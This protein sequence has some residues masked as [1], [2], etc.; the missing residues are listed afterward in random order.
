[1]IKKTLIYPLALAILTVV[2]IFCYL[3]VN[4]IDT[5]LAVIIDG[6]ELSHTDTVT[7]GNNS[8][9]CFNQIPHD[10]LLITKA[11]DAFV[12][13][14]NDQYQDSLQYF[15]INNE[16]P[17]KHLIH[18]DSR[19]HISLTLP[20]CVSDSQDTIHVNLTG[21]EIWKLWE[22]F[23][24]QQDVMVHWL[25]MKFL[26][27]KEDCSHEDSLVFINQMQNNAV[28]SFFEKKNSDQIVMVILD[29]YTSINETIKY[30]YNG[31]TSAVADTAGHCKVQFFG[32]SSYCYRNEEPEKNT[33]HV[34]G[35]NYV[36]KPY[37]KLTEWG[38]GHIML[39]SKDK[40]LRISFPKPVTF[41]GSID[42]LRHVA[43]QTS[44][45]ISLKQS[46][47]AFPT[48]GDMYLPE[49][50]NAINYDLCNI[51]FVQS[52]DSVYIRD[53]NY[54]VQS[55]AHKALLFP[56]FA[57][58]SLSSGDDELTGRVGFINQR[59]V[60]NYLSLPLLLFFIFLI[61]I[62]IKGSPFRLSSSNL[63]QL[64]N[65][66]HIQYYPIYLTTLLTVCLAYCCC[67]SL[68]AIKLSYT[69]P[70]FEKITGII[71]AST[72]MTM[73]LFFSLTMIVNTPL[74]HIT[75]PSWKS[76]RLW[77]GWAVCTVL[78]GLLAYFFFNEIDPQI[79]EGV[80]SS[81]FSSE[82]S[83]ISTIKEGFN[84]DAILDTHRSVVYI[85]IAV[86]AAVLFVWMILNF[87]WKHIVTTFDWLRSKLGKLWII[88]HILL[89][90]FII[91]VGNM[92]GNFG[93]AIITLLVILG[94]SHAL[95]QMASRMT[96]SKHQ[97]R[98][99]WLICMFFTT[100]VYMIAAFWGDHGYLTNYLGFIMFFV[101]ISYMSIRPDTS[102]DEAAY[103]ATKKEKKWVYGLLGVLTVLAIT[104]PYLYI[105]TVGTESVDYSRLN[106]RM[107]LYMEFDDLQKNG[108][109]YSD[110][111]AEFMVIMSHYMQGQETCDPLSNDFHT[112]HASVSSGQS[113]V[114]LND[115]SVPIAFFG[116]YGTV[117]PIAVFFLLLLTLVLLVTK[118]SIDYADHY[119]PAFTVAMQWRMLAMMMWV[120]TS[121]YIFLSYISWLPFTGRL[122]PGF[123]VD[124]VG[125]ALET[126]I[127][128]TFMAATTCRKND[129]YQ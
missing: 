104:L 47:D 4:K 31:K 33:F 10:Y 107:M 111:D 65:K 117:L 40:G 8:S 14:V 22:K 121:C 54:H 78:L 38:A 122:N 9:I 94:L 86:E 72:S 1:M 80:L 126:A 58:I 91:V 62:W 89:L 123:G 114:V 127:L 105:W 92:A 18:N 109:R 42:S 34:D 44:G 26:L 24:K 84:T 73:L 124:A 115:L 81:Y 45:L 76:P 19:Q 75:N 69:Y 21:A 125:E 64:Y 43:K 12:W 30:A 37:V 87:L 101:C 53:N 103:E 85:L 108:Y 7:V 32:I 110:S 112:M 61:F 29:R 55:V 36:M 51:E 48:K 68:I 17:N 95:S 6:L 41:V 71:T 82:T 128:L 77:S 113:P 27:E 2:F 67:K 98:G 49:F 39:E 93:T 99:G 57:K 23:D 70:Y 11:G 3:M 129:Y 96:T 28:R 20:P 102:Y 100:I 66:E 50:S 16:N 79:N 52:N 120:G 119:S 13:E 15:K 83:F 116:A 59:F 35:V 97:Y 88:G 106:R 90:G 60:L 5:K 25:A 56:S 46:N 63:D 118:Y 74:L